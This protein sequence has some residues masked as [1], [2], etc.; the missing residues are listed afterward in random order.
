MRTRLLRNIEVG[1]GLA[2]LDVL[3]RTRPARGA[4]FRVRWPFEPCGGSV[5]TM[6][7]GQ[8][9]A[10]GGVGWVVSEGGNDAAGEKMVAQ[11]IDA[12]DA[13]LEE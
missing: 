5:A 12:E 3:E 11:G 4:A 1:A 2:G 7:S 9:K 8:G 6:S 13:A 10:A